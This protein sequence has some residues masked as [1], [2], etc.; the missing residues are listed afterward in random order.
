MA[1]SGSSGGQPPNIA[2]MS[3][4]ERASRL[5]VRIMTYAEAGKT[6]SVQFFAPMAMA[7]HEML[8]APTIDER[9]HYGRIAEVTGNPTVA[10]AQAESI[11]KERS[12]S[13]LGLLLSA[14]VA[15]LT[16]DNA[17]ARA[18]DQRL[19]KAL[20]PELATKLTDY[21]QHRIE[22]DRAVADARKLK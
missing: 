15:R 4:G 6:D 18:F 5:Y 10:K 3:P 19:L 2:T 12:T 17:T 11:L 1:A 9:Y 20:E 16:G 8:T 7:S 21:D 22:I 13:L 14:R